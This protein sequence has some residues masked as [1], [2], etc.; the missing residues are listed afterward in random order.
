MQNSPKSEF[1]CSVGELE[2]GERLDRFLSQ[3]PYAALN[4]FSRSQVKQLINNFMVSVNSQVQSKAGFILKSGDTVV[5]QLAATATASE[6]PYD[7]ELDVVFEDDELIVINKPAG[8]TVH[9]GANTAGKTLVNALLFYYQKSQSK[10]PQVCES[11]ITSR[12]GIVHRLDKD[13]TGLMVVSKTLLSL[14]NLAKQFAER[15]AKRKYLALVFSTPRG[16]RI[17][18]EQDS[19]EIDLPIGRDPMRRVAMGI[20]GLGQR[21]AITTWKV[22]ERFSYGSLLELS[23]KTGRTHQIRVHVNAVGSPVIGDKTYGDFSGLPLS[24]QKAAQQFGRQALHA[25]YLA[26]THPSSGKELEFSADI[27]EDLRE[28]IQKFSL[29]STKF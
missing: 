27:P 2:N 15:T 3:H 23:L 1:S 20:G 14:Q 6:P 21:H 12:G 10:M 26:F 28:L 5:C 7:F 4:G 19:G 8:L 29:K 9:P 17:I 25:K 18:T 22:I 16:K 24:L 11:L 13:T